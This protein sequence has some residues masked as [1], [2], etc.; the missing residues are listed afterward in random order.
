M[1]K[2]TVLMPVY[3]AEKFV[4]EAIESVL[5]QTFTDFEFLIINDASTD[6][7]EQIISSYKDTRIRYYKNRKNQGVAR[8]LNIGLKLAKGSY[9]ARMDA[10]DIFLLNKLEQQY[11]ILKKDKNL[12]IIC[13]HFDYVDERGNFL[14]SF[15][16]APSPE[17]IYY[18][19]QFRNC[20]GHPTVIFNKEIILN[21]FKGYNEEYEVEDY[22]LWLRISKKYKIVKMDKMLLKVRRSRQSKTELYGNKMLESGAIITQNNLQSLI[23]KPIDLDVTKVLA[24]INPMSIS[25]KKIKEALPTLDEANIEI[26]KNCPPFL[27]KLIIKKSCNH[28]KNLTR[29]FFLMTTL[30]DSMFGPVFKVFYKLYRVKKDSW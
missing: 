20:I 8:T 7:S 24:N 5:N 27:N 3:N 26:L 15:K 21:E 25:P 29:F 2:I 19:L 17:E 30:F 23:G 28:K 11:E 9:I 12:V 6:G 10:D 13:S 14:S 18:E 1:P 16:L 4:S 22:D